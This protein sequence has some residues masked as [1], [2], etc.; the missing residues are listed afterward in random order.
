VGVELTSAVRIGRP[1]QEVFDA[2]LDAGKVAACLPGS[3]LIGAALLTA[4]ALRR[5]RSRTLSLPNDPSRHH[6]HEGA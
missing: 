6:P 2:L 3:R 1:A 5:R 4:L